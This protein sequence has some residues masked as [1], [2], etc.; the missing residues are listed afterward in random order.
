MTHFFTF[1]ANIFYNMMYYYDIYHLKSIIIGSS[2]KAE[3]LLV[4]DFSSFEEFQGKKP[5]GLGS[6]TLSH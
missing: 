5:R 4:I 2:G 3:V 6:G 1:I